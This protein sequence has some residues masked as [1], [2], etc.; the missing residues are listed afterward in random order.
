MLP[1]I[2]DDNERMFNIAPIH[3]PEQAQQFRQTQRL[4]H[5]FIIHGTTDGLGLGFLH[6]LEFVVDRVTGDESGDEG[7]RV[8]AD[9][10]DA[11]ECWIGMHV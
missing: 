1:F 11:A 8:L 2:I 5:L 4:E 7:F 3:L 6:L 9:A 10:E